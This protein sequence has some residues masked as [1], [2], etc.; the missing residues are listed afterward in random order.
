MGNTNQMN[1]GNPFTKSIP[2]YYSY[3]FN[4]TVSGAI[5]KAS[6]FFFSGERRNIGNVNAWAIPLAVIPDGTG[7]YVEEP[8]Y[9]VHL[10]N[11][12]I[13]TNL[14][15]R[16]DWQLG[17]KNTFTARYGFW[18]ETEI[19]NLNAGSLAY[20]PNE[21]PSTH[22]SN[23]D[24]TVQISDAYTINDHIVNETRM[25]YE[26]QNE[27]HYPDSTLP[28][29]SVAGNFTTGGYTGQTYRD[30]ATRLEFQNLTTMSHGA[31]AIKFG[32]RMRDNY[33]SDFTTSNFNGSFRFADANS[34][35]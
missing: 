16:I 1:T 11:Q 33:I 15:S 7:M 10:P 8:N 3:Q 34:Y 4:G 24:H 26:R 5:S 12:R 2:D 14:S 20:I 23:T 22:E 19:G 28:T 6:S 9:G 25:Q 18:S 17:S 13:R 31:H 29:I 35:L 21:S 32:T 27:N 30:H